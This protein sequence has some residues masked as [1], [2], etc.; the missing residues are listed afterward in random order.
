MIKIESDL[1]PSNIRRL[2][3][4]L[5]ELE[6][7]VGGKINKTILRNASKPLRDDIRAH[8]PVGKPRK[9]KRNGSE[10]ETKGGNLRKSI[11]LRTMGRLLRGNYGVVVTAGRLKGKQTQKDDP[12]Y[13]VMYEKGSKKQKARPFLRPA[14]ERHRQ[15]I[16][17][18]VPAQIAKAI[19]QAAKS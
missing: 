13:V 19:E 11:K 12:F 3:R 10:W 2:I 1:N 5:K 15:R 7:K 14:I 17:K 9:V 16:L 4:K 6:P 8:A 18:Q